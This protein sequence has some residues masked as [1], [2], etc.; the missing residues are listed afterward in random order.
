MKKLSVKLMV[1]ALLGLLSSQNCLA[2]KKDKKNAASNAQSQAAS[3]KSNAQSNAASSKSN[4]KDKASK[5]KSDNYV[6]VVIL[7]NTDLPIKIKGS[8]LKVKKGQTKATR[9]YKI[10]TQ[11]TAAD[12]TSKGATSKDTTVIAARGKATY[13]LNTNKQYEYNAMQIKADK[14]EV[15]IATKHGNDFTSNHTWAVATTAST[16]AASNKKDKDKKKASK[17]KNKKNTASA[18]ASANASAPVA[19]AVVKNNTPASKAPAIKAVLA[20]NAFS[21][22]VSNAMSNANSASGSGM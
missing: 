15:K 21:N 16:T 11:E 5:D 18:A 14:S 3:D 8:H 4:A 9:V 12:A 17:D 10:Y 19:A 7:N 1:I 2:D 20:A 6:N 22:A 13:K